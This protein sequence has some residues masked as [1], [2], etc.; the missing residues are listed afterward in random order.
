MG[1]FFMLWFVYWLKECVAWVPWN[2]SGECG[3]Y[4]VIMGYIAWWSVSGV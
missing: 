4:S 3:G 2:R 1:W